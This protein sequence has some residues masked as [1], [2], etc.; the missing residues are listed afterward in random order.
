MNR[1][2]LRRARLRR[3]AKQLTQSLRTTNLGRC[4]VKNQDLRRRMPLRKHPFPGDRAGPEAAYLFLQA[5]PTPLRCADDDVGGVPTRQRALDGRWR[6]T[7]N[8]ALLSLVE[9]G[10]LPCLRQHDWR[11]R[12][13]A[14]RGT[15]GGIFRCKQSQGTR[16][17][18][19]CLRRQASAVVA[20]GGQVNRQ[21]PVGH[22]VNLR[23]WQALRCLR[24]GPGCCMTRAGAACFDAPS[25]CPF[26][27]GLQATRHCT[28]G[29][30]AA[31][32]ARP[33]FLEPT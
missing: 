14:R 24:L 22:A 17:H 29:P 31:A 6:G 8:L 15:G 25:R 28:C 30:V 5:M 19:P 13:Q 33:D 3:A 11:H 27:L 20:S 16:T 4:D 9:S 7:Q 12:R 1:Q 32:R 26:R 21:R 10:V 23:R 18:C 2:K